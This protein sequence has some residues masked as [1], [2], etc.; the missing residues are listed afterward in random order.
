MKI[1]STPKAILYLSTTQ[2]R[3]QLTKR[4]CPESES[5]ASHPPHFY[6]WIAQSLFVCILAKQCLLAESNIK[7]TALQLIRDSTHIEKVLFNL[8]DKQLRKYIHLCQN[9]EWAF[10]PFF[11]YIHR[12]YKFILLPGQS[13]KQPPIHGFFLNYYYDIPQLNNMWD[14]TMLYG[15]VMGMQLLEFANSFEN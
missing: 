13:H 12:A 4:N 10:F 5:W 14:V 7:A 8:K 9:R 1:K 3:F 15:W 2:K 6:F 11:I